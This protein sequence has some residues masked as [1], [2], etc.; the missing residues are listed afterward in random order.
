MRHEPFTEKANRKIIA[1][2]KVKKTVD[3]IAMIKVMT[4]QAALVT[5]RRFLA[6]PL[7]CVMYPV[8][9]SYVR[10]MNKKTPEMTASDTETTDATPNW[11]LS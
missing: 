6:P 7:D 10:R 2:G 4:F 11:P 3:T 8:R 9:C 5:R 1:S